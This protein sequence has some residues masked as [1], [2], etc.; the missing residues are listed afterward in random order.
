MEASREE[1]RKRERK[2]REERKGEPG[3][4]KKSSGS[5]QVN[6]ICHTRLKEESPE[7]TQQVTSNLSR[8]GKCT[9]KRD[10]RIKEVEGRAPGCLWWGL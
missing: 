9:L 3:P 10:P 8:T 2:T 5:P 7:K 4:T 1:K 6:K